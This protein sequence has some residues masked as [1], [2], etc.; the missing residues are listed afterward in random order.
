MLVAIRGGRKNTDPTYRCAAMEDTPGRYCVL[1]VD[2]S[3][4]VQRRLTLPMT[5]KRQVEKMCNQSSVPVYVDFRKTTGL[6]PALELQRTDVIDANDV[7]LSI[8]ANKSEE[9]KRTLRSLYARTTA[10]LH[11]SAPV[12]R[13]AAASLGN[14]SFATSTDSE[15]FVQKHYG[16]KESGLHSDVCDVIAK[17]PEWKM[18]R[19]HAH[20]CLDRLST[21]LTAHADIDRA[22]HAFVRD[23]AEGGLEVLEK[24]V[25]RIGYEASEPIF[26]GELVQPHDTFSLNADF[27]PKGSQERAVVRRFAEV[28]QDRSLSSHAERTYRNAEAPPA[29]EPRAGAIL[30][31]IKVT[32]KDRPHMEAALKELNPTLTITYVTEQSTKIHAPMLVD[33]SPGSTTPA[34]V[35]SSA[36]KMA[37]FEPAIP[38]EVFEK[39]AQGVKAAAQSESLT[40]KLSAMVVSL[41][42]RTNANE[43]KVTLKNNVQLQ[44]ALAGLAPAYYLAVQPDEIERIASAPMDHPFITELASAIVDYTNGHILHRE[45]DY[46]PKYKVIKSNTGYFGIGGEEQVNKGWNMV[47]SQWN[48]HGARKAKADDFDKAAEAGDAVS[49]VFGKNFGILPSFDG[50]ARA[51]A[52]HLNAPGRNDGEEGSMTGVDETLLSDAKQIFEGFMNAKAPDRMDDLGKWVAARLDPKTWSSVSL[53]PMIPYETASFTP[54]EEQMRNGPAPYDYKSILARLQK[55]ASVAQQS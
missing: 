13:G 29:P 51:E 49:Y 32:F 46:I 42:R 39:Q 22:E 27:R 17:T 15:S 16:L 26:R 53:W 48:A 54:V 47:P 35:E 3:G 24:P 25:R 50:S 4:R 1:D 9:E 20:D 55:L 14:P 18:H 7:M 10:R 21:R 8:R 30:A 28:Y 45:S 41:L 2:S 37:M 33:K 19:Q 44:V 40:E 11:E 52:F 23:M 6:V 5:A 12:F 36:G 34:Y 31:G 38:V 43:P